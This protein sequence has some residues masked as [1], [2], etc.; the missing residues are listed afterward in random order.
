MEERIALGSG[1]IYLEE[2]PETLET[3]LEDLDALIT[4]YCV[5]DKEFGAVKNG[6]MQ[7]I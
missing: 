1:K 2:R 7:K 4:K 6:A 3:D 5:A